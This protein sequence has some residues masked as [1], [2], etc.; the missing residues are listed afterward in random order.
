M[1]DDASETVATANVNIQPASQPPGQCPQ[2]QVGTP[3][4]CHAPPPGSH[5]V[6]PRLHGKTPVA[7]KHAL[8]V[9]GCAIGTVHKPRHKPKRR[10]GFRLL[11]VVTGQS[12]APGAQKPA[13]TKVNLTLGY[14]R[15]KLTRRH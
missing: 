15:V 7:A 5:C 6:V 2:G 9:A 4:D 14:K 10:R 1:T 8:R 3:P 12:L 11:K 13:G